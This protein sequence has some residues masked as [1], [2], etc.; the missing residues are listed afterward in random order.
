MQNP[1][2]DLKYELKKLIIE[3]LNIQNVS[4]EDISDDIPLFSGNN[5]I[6]LD[7][8][9]ALEIIMA[10]QRIYKVRIDDQN[11]ARVVLQTINSIADF[12]TSQRT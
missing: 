2:S 11:L 4:P 7:S 9:D 12:I 3:T 10:I 6:G 8:I 5:V 1:D